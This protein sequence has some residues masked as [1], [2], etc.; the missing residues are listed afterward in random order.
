MDKKETILENASAM[1]RKYGYQ[2]AKLDD[3]ANE[4]GM[5]KAGLYYYFKNK[6]DLFMAMLKRD[7]DSVN[8]R[9]RS[10]LSGRTAPAAAI[11]E[12]L[13]IR[14]KSYVLM[15]EYLDMFIGGV[16][17][18]R[19]RESARASKNRMIQEEINLVADYLQG[20]HSGDPLAEAE[21]R[22]IVLI[23]LGL[24]DKIG[25][26]SLADEFKVDIEETLNLAVSLLLN[27]LP[28]NFKEYS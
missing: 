18:P 25:T 9:L 8:N 6:E 19:L 15:K 10:T 24:S 4:C 20:H 17:P 16:T 26:M 2:K 21:L 13:I 1:F 11:R 28:I 5:N 3:I 7:I 27:H 22:S 12:F 23:L 14:T